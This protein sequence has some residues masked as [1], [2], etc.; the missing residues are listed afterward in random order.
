[1]KRPINR[2]KLFLVAA[3]TAVAAI[4]V[5]LLGCS[6]DSISGTKLMTL[7]DVRFLAAKGYDLHAEDFDQYK[8]ESRNDA[9]SVVYTLENGYSLN[10]MYTPNA[11]PQMITLHYSWDGGICTF[12]IRS[13]DEHQSDI[14]EFL[15]QCATI[16]NTPLPTMIISGA[17]RQSLSYVLVNETKI[18]FSCNIGYTIEK[19]DTDTW[20]R[21]KRIDDDSA[22]AVQDFILPANSESGTSTVFF[23][24]H[25]ED[26]EAGDYRFST[27]VELPHSHG[28]TSFWIQ[29]EFSIT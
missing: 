4:L 17:S 3:V 24:A 16:A 25:Y 14:E 1:M 13:Y 2:L 29:Q 11:E 18:E 15:K 5:M 10:A 21:L 12:Y 9:L 28:Y 6:T 7:D 27:P 8:T 26:L 20:E 19:R 23:K 22:S